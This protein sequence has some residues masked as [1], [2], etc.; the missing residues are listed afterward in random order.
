MVTYGEPRE[1]KT[2]TH[3]CPLWYLTSHETFRKVGGMHLNRNIIIITHSRA[4]LQRGQG[5][6]HNA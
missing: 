4:W 2:H 3:I 6:G 1:E 5:L